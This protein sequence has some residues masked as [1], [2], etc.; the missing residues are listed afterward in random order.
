MRALAPARYLATGACRSGR[1]P[2]GSR[3]ALTGVPPGDPWQ[4]VA[5]GKA[6]AA[7]TLGAIDAQAPLVAHALVISKAGH[8]PAELDSHARVEQ[9]VAGHPVPDEDTLAAGARLL[10]LLASLPSDRRHP[11]SHLRWQL[12][13]GRSVAWGASLQELQRVNAW[14]LASGRDIKALN[15]ILQTLLDAQG[16]PLAGSSGRSRSAGP[17]DLRCSRRRS[18][19][20][21]VG[22][23]RRANGRG[24]A[25]GP[26]VLASRTPG[27]DFC[28][29]PRRAPIAG[30]RGGSWRRS[31]TPWR[32]RA[33]RT[34][35]G[36]RDSQSSSTIRR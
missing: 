31:T 29:W 11:V 7:M 25:V 3:E 6:A 23:R 35:D 20:D 16:W 22:S 1:P 24:P 2:S 30:S 18:E 32:C 26:A 9:L 21:R 12:E 17:V 36:P 19:H 10:D 33:G 34:R 8:F 5:V 14:A 15:S 28:G 27:K 4:I 13:P